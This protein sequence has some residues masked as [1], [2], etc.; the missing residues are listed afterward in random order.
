MN[1]ENPSLEKVASLIERLPV[2][3]KMV[4][5]DRLLKQNDLSIAL[6]ESRDLLLKQIA[7]SADKVSPVEVLHAIA[8]KLAKGG[9]CFL[10]AVVGGVSS[11]YGMVIDDDD[12]VIP[13]GKREKLGVVTRV[14]VLWG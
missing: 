4:V 14:K 9:L 12:L 3:Q 6:G 13:P 7:N 2:E 5:V 10:I 11:S 8:N 1:E